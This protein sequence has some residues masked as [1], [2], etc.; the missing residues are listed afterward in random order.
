M[1][2][3]LGVQQPSVRFSKIIVLV[4][5]G[6]YPT[7]WNFGMQ[8]KCVLLLVSVYIQKVE[9]KEKRNYFCSSQLYIRRTIYLDKNIFWEFFHFLLAVVIN[10]FQ[11]KKTSNKRIYCHIE[12]INKTIFASTPPLLFLKIQ[13]VRECTN[14][15]MNPFMCVV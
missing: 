14:W 5:F 11:T 4:H 2:L 13:N 7:L 10:C 15:F 6:F 9:N 3:N 12:S 1:I 8:Q